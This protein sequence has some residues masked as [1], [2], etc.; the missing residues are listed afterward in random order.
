MSD[1][2]AES[3]LERD[4]QHLS[5]VTNHNFHDATLQSIRVLAAP[6]EDEQT[7]IEVLLSFPHAQ[8]LFLLTFSGCTNVSL[9]LDFDVLADNLPYN[10]SGFSTLSDAAEIQQFITAQVPAWNVSYDDM[11]SSSAGCFGDGDS[12]L[13]AKLARA[14]SLTLH[15][16]GYFGG[17]LS[18]VAAS[19]D[20]RLVRFDSSANVR[21]G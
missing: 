12:P 21:N 8:I 20:I 5:D 4:R 6:S 11:W 18:I 7:Q 15:R 10:T 17:E 1:L 13:K 9:A 2:P 3:A 19:H 14:A 16:I